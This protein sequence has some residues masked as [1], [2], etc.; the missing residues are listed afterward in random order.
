MTLA[1]VFVKSWS[2]CDRGKRK[3]EEASIAAARLAEEGL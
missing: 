3:A 2:N 1:T